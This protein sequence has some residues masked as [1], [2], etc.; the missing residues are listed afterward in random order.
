MVEYGKKSKEK[1]FSKLDL[2]SKKENPS[3]YQKFQ[4]MREMIA[5]AEKKLIFEFRFTN[6]TAFFKAKPILKSEVNKNSSLRFG[7]YDLGKYYSN[8]SINLLEL[9]A[10]GELFLIKKPKLKWIITK[11]IKKI[12]NYNCYKATTEIIINSKGKKE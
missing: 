11:E 8:N 10:F 6:N 3:R 2:K 5:E 7:P 9:N 4:K 1:V 12:G